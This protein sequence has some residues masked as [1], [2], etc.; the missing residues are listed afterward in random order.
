[1]PGISVHGTS[2]EAIKSLLP[3]FSQLS[4]W[5]LG[6][7]RIKCPTAWIRGLLKT[8][9]YNCMVVLP[10]QL[11]SLLLSDANLTFY[12][13]KKKIHENFYNLDHA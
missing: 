4:F 11:S 10:Q 6:D 12:L 13:K 8:L 5:L 1:M 2:A 9:L 7:L 3:S